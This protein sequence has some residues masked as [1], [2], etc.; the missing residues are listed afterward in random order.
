MGEDASPF[1]RLVVGANGTPGSNRAIEWVSAL[2][3]AVG[4]EVVVVHVL[5][6]DHELLRD[7]TL[8]TMRTW[9]R[10]LAQALRTEWAAPLVAAGVPHRCS[11]VEGET[12]SEVLS[13]TAINEGADVIVV[14][15]SDHGREISRLAHRAKLPVVLV[16]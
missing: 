12:V 1:T 5:T 15:A 9:R 2:A 14:G 11:V 10:E 8:D 13:R 16:P 6:Y 3:E 7:L 4:S